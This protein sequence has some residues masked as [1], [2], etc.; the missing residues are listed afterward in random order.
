[1]GQAQPREEGL[2]A[3]LVTSGDDLLAMR[4]FLDGRTAYSAADVIEY[5][6]AGAAVSMT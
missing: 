5:L 1:V 2:E 3:P 6:Q 4:P